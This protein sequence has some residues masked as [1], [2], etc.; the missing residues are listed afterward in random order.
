MAIN[1]KAYIEEFVKIRDKNSRIIP[2]KLNAPQMRL[3]QIIQE[4]SKKRQPIRIIILKA[5]QMGFS[6]VSGGVI[7][8]NTATKA[9]VT[10]AIVAHKEDSA[11]NLFNMYKLMYDNLPLEIKPTKKASNAKELIFN[12]DNNTGLNSRIRC[13]TAG[14]QGIGRSF[15]INYLHI[16]ELAFWEGNPK[17]TLLGLFQ[18][19]PNT[20]DSMIIIEST[21]NGFE[22]F[23]DMWDAAVNG[24]SDF[25]PL[26]VGWNELDQYQMPYDGSIFTPEEVDL[27]NRYHLTREQIMWRRWCIKN[28]C[29]GDVDMFKQEYP[30]TPQEAFLATGRCVFNQENIEKRLNNLPDPV[31]RG[32]FKYTNTGI[33]LKDIQFMDDERGSIRI[34]E[35]PRPNHKYVIG[36]DTAGEGSDYF[37]AHVLDNFDGRQVAVYRCPTDETLFTHQMYCLGMLYNEALIAIETNFS[38]YPNKELERLRYPHIFVRQRE[39]NFTHSI[40]E[41]FGFRTTMQTRPIIISM[42]TDVIRECPEIINDRILLNE[43]LTFVRNDKGR[44]EAMEGKHD[45]AVISYGI[46]LYARG[47]QTVILPEEVTPRKLFKW[48]DDLKQDYYKADKETRE[49]MREKYGEPN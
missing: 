7:L 24:E 3:Y 1:T 33:T 15:T 14:A 16:S 44:A 21:A 40:T 47:Q 18:A 41:S 17:E 5:R 4:Q 11:S 46:A 39:D 42:I 49:R 19:V 23:K 10:S 2:F 38:T 8:K 34:W 48:S 30:I 12:N 31:R 27:M 28:N 36:A 43:C 32:E 13:M 29:G 35:E 6:T 22:T 25:Y 37:Y 45:D 20:P 26:F 9:N